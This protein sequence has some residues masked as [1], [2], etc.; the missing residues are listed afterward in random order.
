MWKKTSKEKESL[1]AFINKWNAFG[2]ICGQE[3]V[4]YDDVLQGKLP[5]SEKESTLVLY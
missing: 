5:W 1:K 2:S 4:L 3:N